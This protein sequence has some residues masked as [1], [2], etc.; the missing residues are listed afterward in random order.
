MLS[1][2]GLQRHLEAEGLVHEVRF[3]CGAQGAHEQRLAGGETQRMADLN[4]RVLQA[5]QGQGAFLIEGIEGAW[6]T[7]VG[8]P[9]SILGRYLLE[10]GAITA[11]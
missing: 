11:G 6:T 1:Q 9:V 2:C 8:L 10:S 7:V 3:I 4:R 5:V